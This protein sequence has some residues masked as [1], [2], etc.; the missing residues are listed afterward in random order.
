MLPLLIGTMVVLRLGQVN[1]S[2]G[3]RVLAISVATRDA[4]SPHA[5]GAR[6]MG[7][8]GMRWRLCLGNYTSCPVESPSPAVCRSCEAERV[9]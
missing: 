5:V 8:A 2:G 3:K 7:A 9:L 4:H 1:W 6:H